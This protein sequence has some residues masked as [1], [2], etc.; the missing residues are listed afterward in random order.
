MAGCRPGSNIVNVLV[1]MCFVR[2]N[3]GVPPTSVGPTS[4]KSR[5]CYG[6]DTEEPERRREVARELVV[7][8]IINMNGLLF[9]R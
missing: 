7:Y 5:S 9:L 6:D 3:N 8:D 4:E 2:R 1:Y